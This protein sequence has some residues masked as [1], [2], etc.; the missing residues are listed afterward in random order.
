MKLQ[1]LLIYASISISLYGGEI[2]RSFIQLDRDLRSV[3]NKLKV[4]KAYPLEKFIKA[5]QYYGIGARQRGPI[6]FDDQIFQEINK[7]TCVPSI[8]EAAQLI[9]KQVHAANRAFDIE[10]LHFDISLAQQEVMRA[11]IKAAGE[12]ALAAV[13]NALTEGEAQIT[14]FLLLRDEITQA[15]PPARRKLTTEE[16]L[17]FQEKYNR[18]RVSIYEAFVDGKLSLAHY[19]QLNRELVQ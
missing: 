15:Q 10:C 13:R 19:N 5:K 11:G 7:R 17:E 3:K 8:E 2:T 4:K 18:I 6:A 16:T 1:C 14:N 9:Q 12:R